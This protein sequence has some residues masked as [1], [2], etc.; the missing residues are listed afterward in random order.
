MTLTEA[1]EALLKMP[2]R[3]RVPV[4]NDGDRIDP[5]DS[6]VI[7]AGSDRIEEIVPVKWPHFMTVITGDA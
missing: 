6:A 5:R 1:Y 2:M 7:D 4:F 3:H